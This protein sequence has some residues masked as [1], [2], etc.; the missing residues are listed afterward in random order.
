MIFGQ[1]DP[2]KTPYNSWGKPVWELFFISGKCL[3]QRKFFSKKSAK[4]K[5]FQQAKIICFQPKRQSENCC[6]SCTDRTDLR[7]VRT[8][9]T[10]V[11]TCKD[12]PRNSCRKSP[13]RYSCWKS[14]FSL[15]CSL[16]LPFSACSLCCS[17]LLKCCLGVCAKLLPLSPP[18]PEISLA[19]LLSFSQSAHE[20]MNDLF[21]LFLP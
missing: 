8:V 1:L 2:G 19:L 13:P 3:L 10:A 11:R 21:L 12:R 16:N 7:T 9:R 14:I 5:F 17:D 6:K 18:C 4:Q 20:R 15:F